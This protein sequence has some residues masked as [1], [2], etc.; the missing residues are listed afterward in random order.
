MAKIDSS[1]KHSVWVM[2]RNPVQVK[3][4]SGSDL[5]GCIYGELWGH[6]SSP[7]TEWLQVFIECLLLVCYTG[8][9]QPVLSY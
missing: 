7:V 6:S 1:I 4:A 8:N 5:V 3:P 9:L 2:P